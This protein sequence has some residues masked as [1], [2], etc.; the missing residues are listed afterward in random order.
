MRIISCCSTIEDCIRRYGTDA[1]TCFVF[2]SRIAARLW[3]HRALVLTGLTAVPAE[4][5]IVSPSTK[6]IILYFFMDLLIISCCK[7]IKILENVQNNN[8]PEGA[9]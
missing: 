1:R 2:P 7:S 8:N 9:L 3:M 4:L 6:I 5:F